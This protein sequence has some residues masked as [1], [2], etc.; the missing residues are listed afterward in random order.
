[1]L[2]RFREAGAEQ[3]LDSNRAMCRAT[4]VLAAQI[5][6]NVIEDLGHAWISC[7]GRAVLITQVAPAGTVRSRGPPLLSPAAAGSREA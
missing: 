1:M 2:L 7:L 3:Q 5:F 6:Y 4:R